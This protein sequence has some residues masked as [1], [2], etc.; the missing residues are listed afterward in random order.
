MSL[1]AI[2]ALAVALFCGNLLLS[3]RLVRQT[4]ETWVAMLCATM[5][6]SSSF[7]FC[8]SRL[9]IVEP[10]LMFLTLLSLLIAARAKPGS[11]MVPLTMGVLFFLMVLSKT[12][13]VFILPAILYSLWFPLRREFWSFARAVSTMGAIC[14]VLWGVYFFRL[15]RPRY[16]EDYRYFFHVNVYE[17]PHA[18]LGWLEVFYRAVHDVLWVDAMLAVL[19]VILIGA[20]SILARELWRKPLFVS[21]LLAIGG[22]LLFVTYINNMQPRYYAVVAFF[23]FIAVAMAVAALLRT[24]RW[25]GVLALA[26]CVF[27]I[28][29]SAWETG[30]FVLLSG[31]HLCKRSAEPDRLHRRTSE[32][33]AVS[34]CRS[35]A[36]ISPLITGIPSLCDD[37]GT[38]ELPDKLGLYQPGWYAA[39]N[40]LDPGSL[41]DL[42]THYSL[43]EV[44]SFKAFDDDDRDTLNL[45]KLVALPKDGPRPSGHHH[46]GHPVESPPRK[47]DDWGLKRLKRHGRLVLPVRLIASFL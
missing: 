25:A 14:A 15:V 22:Y 36:T 26:L 39:W 46:S 37:F 41:D 29:K 28:G 16:L 18:L 5:I 32:R 10:L 19:C 24:K 45:Y 34:G 42:H 7:L 27:A 4:E 9:A 35:A 43:D 3:Y 47:P 38:M 21:S 23:L 44:A 30:G 8:L 1:V 31:I 40:D 33:K 11:Y 2:R 6:A 20:T 12:T 13:A 17:K